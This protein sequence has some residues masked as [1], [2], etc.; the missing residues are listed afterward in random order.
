MSRFDEIRE[1]CEKATKG[2]WEAL[3][4]ANLPELCGK[5]I[6]TMEELTKEMA[7]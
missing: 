4:R 2:P 3:T 7:I 6:G 1:R 5:K